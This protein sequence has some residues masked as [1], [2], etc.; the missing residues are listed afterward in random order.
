VSTQINVSVA[1][2]SLRRLS[3]AQVNANRQSKLLED[4]RRKLAQQSVDTQAQSEATQGRDVRGQLLYGVKSDRQRPQPQPFAVYRTSSTGP[5]TPGSWLLAPSDASFNAIVAGLAPFQFTEAYL[6]YPTERNS[7]HFGT[8]SSTGPAGR[9]CIQTSTTPTGNPTY[10]TKQ[11]NCNIIADTSIITEA[12]SGEFTIEA[13]AKMDVFSDSDASTGFEYSFARAIVLFGFCTIEFI[14]TWQRTSISPATYAL[15]GNA[16]MSCYTSNYRAF[17]SSAALF[18]LADVKPELNDGSRWHHAAIVQSK[19]PG[20]TGREVYFYL[21]GERVDQVT[22]LPDDFLSSWMATHSGAGID[23]SVDLGY[24]DAN[25]ATLEASSSSIH[26]IRY[27]PRA[28][29]T[30]A[31]FTPPTSITSLA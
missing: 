19:G 8:F 29:Y 15:M 13:I 21:N 27:T 12:S 5:A 23:A 9:N 3:Q 10:G 1:L 31:S 25:A 14:Y 20:G 17:G 6:Q 24:G 11:Y 22:G 26:G 16:R 4:Q 30:G 7:A 18:P 28:L 2:E